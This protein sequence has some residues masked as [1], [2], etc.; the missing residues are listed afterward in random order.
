MDAIPRQLYLHIQLRI[1]ALYYSRVIRVFKDAEVSMPDIQRMLYN[2]PRGPGYETWA[3]GLP[4]TTFTLQSIPP[5]VYLTSNELDSLKTA[6]FWRSWTEF[7]D[8]LI[9]EWQTQT[10]VNGLLIS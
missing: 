8:S 2:S 10:I 6:S 4:S 5:N 1:P 3:Q 7:I 9:A